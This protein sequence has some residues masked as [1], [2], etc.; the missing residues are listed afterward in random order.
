MYVDDDPLPPPD[1]SKNMLNLVSGR[2][3]LGGADG[4]DERQNGEIPFFFLFPAGG[5]ERAR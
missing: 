3:T 5:G 4:D 1:S 2:R